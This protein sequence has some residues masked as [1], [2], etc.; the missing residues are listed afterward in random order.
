[1]AYTKIHAITAT[2]NKA[3]DYICAPDKTDGSIL[4]SSCGCS[5]QTASFDFEF[6]LSKTSRADKNKAYHLIQSFFPG[7]VSYEEAHQ[8]GNELAEKLLQ[9]K[10][11]YIV[12]THI[13]KGH[14]HNHI[15]FCA[16]DN[17]D[18]KKYHDCKQ[19]Y[20]NIRKL[21]DSL[22]REHNLSVIPDSNRKGK[23]YKEWMENQNN[24]S[25]KYQVR[26]DINDSIKKASTYEKFLEIMASKGYNIE[27]SGFH[28]SGKYIKFRPQGQ[29]Y[30]VRGREKTLG[31][32]YT[33]ER[34]RER[35]ENKGQELANKML[36]SRG[37]HNI[38]DTS[39]DEK[40]ANNAALQ[41]WADKQNLKLA[42]QAYASMEQLGLHS[43]EELETQL[44]TLS[45]QSSTAKT[46]TVSL[47]KKLRRHALIL[48]YAE[49]YAEN[50]PFHTRYTKAQNKESVF[51]KYESKLIL[52]DGAKNELK[53][54]GL[55]P[56]KVNPDE[57][58]KDY[59]E[60]DNQRKIFLTEYKN[61]EKSLK[62]L[63]H[64]KDVISQYMD[65]APIETHQ[66]SKT[67]VKSRETL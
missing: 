21:S 52:Y 33:K 17:I 47:E 39:A 43:M 51:R 35:I 48:K 16:A 29:K 65:S 9:N 14:I 37:I 13:D 5:P 50:H 30:F 18:H 8:I 20:Y 54:F 36:H 34:I 25:W 58:R 4:I 28:N 53:R 46:Q 40:Y 3:V 61:T 42:A 2:V 41:K 10:Y 60:M 7:E 11:S 23:S 24:H 38:I 12:S 59:Q 66:L 31:K 32:D 27:N 64:L 45:E 67:S 15:I 19:T 22:C 6:A 44:V 26:A 63:Q 57:V 1:M 56:S 49:Q 55:E 62:E